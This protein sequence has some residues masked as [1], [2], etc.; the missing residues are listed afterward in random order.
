LQEGFAPP[1]KLRE[2]HQEAPPLRRLLRKGERPL[3]GLPGLLPAPQPA[4]QVGAGGMG[5]VVVAEVAAVEDGVD[6]LEP[7][8]RD[9]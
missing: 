8:R 2:S 3:I 6:E 4:K 7:G 1:S 5:Q 9:S